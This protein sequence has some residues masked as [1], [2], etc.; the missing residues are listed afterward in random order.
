MKRRIVATILFFGIGCSLL[1]GAVF[2][3]EEPSAADD[4]PEVTQEEVIQN[5]EES[6]PI[7]DAEEAEEPF[8]TGNTEEEEP[9]EELSDELSADV[10]VTEE[11]DATMH[12][13]A[14]HVEGEISARAYSNNS[15]SSQYRNSVYYERLQ[16]AIASII[17]D[18]RKDIL[19]IAYSQI[20]YH[21]GNS[22]S[23]LAGGNSY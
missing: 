11:T 7:E 14:S 23:D 18:Q 8:G 9:V 10:E 5:T 1:Q 20:G 13:D 6:L 15:Q 12:E 17:N 4:W 21:E 19:R 2:A 3:A 16:T 22:S